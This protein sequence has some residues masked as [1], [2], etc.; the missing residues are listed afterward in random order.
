[1]DRLNRYVMS[2][3]TISKAAQSPKGKRTI[4]EIQIDTVRKVTKTRKR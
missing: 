1:M 4:N 3:P 2:I